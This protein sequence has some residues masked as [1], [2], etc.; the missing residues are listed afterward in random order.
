MTRCAWCI[1]AFLLC[2]SIAAPVMGKNYLLHSPKLWT[3]EEKEQYEKENPSAAME[4]EAAELEKKQAAKEK[5][6]AKKEKERVARER[7]QA[8]KEKEQIKKEKE[9]VAKEREQ[10]AKEKERL[11]KVTAQI[12]KERE[13][14][15]REKERIKKEREKARSNQILVKDG[16]SYREVTVQD[17]DTLY[18]ISLKYSKEGASYAETVR[19]NNI[20][21]QDEIA[22]G[23]I[24]NVPLFRQKKKEKKEA[25]PVKPVKQVRPVA[26]APLKQPATEKTEV[27]KVP[28]NIEVL[29]SKKFSGYSTSRQK[30]II[31][32][33]AESSAH[34]P[35]KTDTELQQPEKL[36]EA[37]VLLGQKLFEQAIK[38]YR[39]G[40]CQTAIQLFTRYLG[41]DTTSKFAADASLLIA[42]CY[43]RLSGK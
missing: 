42:D 14:V 16:V 39:S 35:A 1:A 7:E 38:S 40:D 32:P 8:I 31:Q 19:F 24:I 4:R 27:I 43:L 3:P 29:P 37:S 21:D 10:A 22:I 23:D 26:A 28:G 13:Q 41:E 20:A 6:Q 36:P 12:Q 18:G 34:I 5:E 15:K 9:R 11:R 30:A 25:K 33:P 2:F 17:G